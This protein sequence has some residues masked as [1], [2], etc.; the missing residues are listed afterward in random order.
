MT[1]LLQNTIHQ[2]G[3]RS[4]SHP[5]TRILMSIFTMMITWQERIRQRRDLASLPN[6]LLKDIGFT[7]ADIWQ[8]I[9]K[10]FW[11]A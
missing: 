2:G 9:E 7:R 3:Y 8:E 1:D 6:Y 4:S 5:V 10:P 11:Q